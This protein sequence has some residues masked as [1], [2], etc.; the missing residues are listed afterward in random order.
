M[1]RSAAVRNQILQMPPAGSRGR[2][3]AAR[4][5]LRLRVDLT[6]NVARE[7]LDVDGEESR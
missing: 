2:S 1:L 3:S 5:W 7:S 6:A 4:V